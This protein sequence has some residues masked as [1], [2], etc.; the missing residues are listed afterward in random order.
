[1]IVWYHVTMK[2]VMIV[3]NVPENEADAMRQ[4]IGDA[5]GGVMGNYSYCSFS[6]TGKGRFTP[7][8][9]ANPTIGSSNEP[10]VVAEERI[11]VSCQEADAALVVAAIKAAHS[12]EEPAISVYPLL[13]I[14]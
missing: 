1:M 12:Y 9:A 6:V 8:Q 10:E 4:A 14:G 5:G 2:R 7:N 13:D 3:V 11:E